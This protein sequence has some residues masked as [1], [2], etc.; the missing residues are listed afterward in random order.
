MG[1]FHHYYIVVLIYVNKRD[2]VSVFHRC[3]GNCMVVSVRLFT[4][5]WHDAR[6]TNCQ[7]IGR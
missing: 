1:C 3:N 5:G 2:G 6:P 7:Q 4:E